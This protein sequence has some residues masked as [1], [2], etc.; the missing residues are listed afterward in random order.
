M[1]K[2]I[3]P[4]DLVFHFLNVGFGDNILIELPADKNGDRSYGLVDCCDHKKTKKYLDKLRRIRPG[5]TNFRFICATHPH[6]DHISGINGFLKEKDYRPEEFWESGFRHQ[7]KTYMN[8]IKSI[9]KH[10]IKLV[11]VS[12][13]MERYYGKVQVTALSPSIRLRNR[14]AT[15]GVDMNNSSVV[16]RFEHHKK[17]YLLTKSLEYKGTR[18]KEIERRAGRSVVILAGDAEFDSWAYVADEYPRLERSKT[19]QPLVKKVINPLAC[20]V[21]KVAHHGSMHSSPLDIYEKMNPNLAIISTKQE[22]STKH[23]GNMTLKRGLFPHPSSISSLEEVGATILTTDGCYESTTIDGQLK[24][25]NY[26]RCGTIVIVVPPGGNPRY[27]KLDD[28]ENTVKDPP[29][30]V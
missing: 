19:H 13:G 30:D 17:D 20:R 7:S 14:Y 4:E 8:I 21:I 3:Q 24:N 9:H 18:S 11:R 23:I 27:D 26:D 10:D 22:V 2:P 16:L 5:D 29:T 12:S 1:P 15:F 25:P 28:D 6:Y